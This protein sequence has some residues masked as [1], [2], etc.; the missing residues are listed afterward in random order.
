MEQERFQDRGV[1]G[2][3]K[4][5]VLSRANGQSCGL[6]CVF[7]SFEQSSKRVY[8]RACGLWFQKKDA[9]F[10]YRGQVSNAEWGEG[11]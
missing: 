3:P 6:Q 2:A 8:I 9:K 7:I 10:N 1:G 5:S 11:K 4:Q